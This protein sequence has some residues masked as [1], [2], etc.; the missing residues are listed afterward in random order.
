MNKDNKLGQVANF[1]LYLILQAT[2]AR[3]IAFSQ[4]GCFVYVGFF[5]ILPGRQKN[6]TTLLCISF[7]FG[8][9]IDMIY[10]SIGL[11]AFASVL[12]VY[13]RSFLL[14]LFLPLNSQKASTQ[15]T[16]AQLGGRQFTI[17]ALP[18]I[19]IHHAAW[20]FLDASDISLF[21]AIIRKLFVSVLLTYVAVVITQIITS[22]FNKQ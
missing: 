6:L 15:L 14:N 12:M 21:F 11:H 18:L 8:L 9:L 4:A 22:L 17:F 3:F 16:L 2:V 13:S 7:I 19:L 1:L 10:H 20:F 5:L